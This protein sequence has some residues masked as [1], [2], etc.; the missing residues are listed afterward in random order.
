MMRIPS[1][2]AISTCCKIELSAKLP[3]ILVPVKEK[4]LTFSYAP[5]MRHA[6]AL[7][8]GNWLVGD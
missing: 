7:G 4:M 2:N 8:R 5:D 3:K 1:G 6:I